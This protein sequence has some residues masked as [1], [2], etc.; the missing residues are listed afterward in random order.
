[1]DPSRPV[2]PK[3]PTGPEGGSRNRLAQS[4]L[5]GMIRPVVEHLESPSEREVYALAVIAATAFNAV[6]YEAAGQPQVAAE[7]VARL[8]EAGALD[9]FTRPLF[10][11]WKDE[12]ALFHADEDWIYDMVRAE[13]RPDGQVVL[14]ATAVD[15][16]PH[17]P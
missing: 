4:V 16:P 7:G 15:C 6:R 14:I 2:T 8:E 11:R 9:D 5:A 17:S 10:A 3:L 1:M 12:V 13:K